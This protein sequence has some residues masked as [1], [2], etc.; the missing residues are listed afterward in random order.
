MKRLLAFMSILVFVPFLGAMDASVTT[1]YPIGMTV[2]PVS[3]SIYFSTGRIEQ[4]G[5]ITITPGMVKKT[6]I[7]FD[8]DSRVLSKRDLSER[9]AQ[10]LVGRGVVQAVEFK[11]KSP[12][13]VL[14]Q[15]MRDSMSTEGTDSQ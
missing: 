6:Y 1:E 9:F 11:F 4:N 12:E 15:K 7:W 2:S 10:T 14:A 13:K 5:L 3:R 8:A